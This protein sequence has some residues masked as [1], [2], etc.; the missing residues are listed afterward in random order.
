MVEKLQSFHYALLA[1]FTLAVLIHAQD[2]SG[3]NFLDDLSSSSQKKNGFVIPLVVSVAATFSALIIGLAIFCSLKARRKHVVSEVETQLASK[4]DSF[5]SKHW[6]FAYS[7]VIRI[8]K[9]FA[10]VLGRGGFGTVYHGRIDNIEVAVKMLSPSSAQGYKEF[11][12][13]VELLMR[14]HHRNLIALVGYC[15]EG[16]NMGL[17]YEYMPRGTL[18]QH[19]AGNKN[20]YFL[21]WEER[22]QI[23]LDAAQGLE[24]LHNGCKPPMVHRDVKPSNILLNEKLQA[25][26]ADSGL[27]RVF[28]T[29]SSTSISTV[30]AGTT[31]YLD[32]E[33]ARGD[34]RKIVHPRL[35]ENF[36]INSAWKAVELALASASHA[37]SKRPTMIEVVMG[38]KECLA[39]QLGQNDYANATVINSTLL[40]S[41]VAPLAR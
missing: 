25:K 11:H 40:D 19:L 18:E 41:D 9:N 36:N 22:M 20:Q 16:F 27:S 5:A 10:T 3:V 6:R 38:L 21:S 15:I 35:G 23:A 30:V 34:I 1:G 39:I 32:P 14:V 31:G 24:Y 26:I 12:A 8:T 7:D 13:E 37:S 29:E 28:A 17:I 33:L 4:N 2:Q